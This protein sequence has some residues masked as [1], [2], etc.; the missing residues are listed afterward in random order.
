MWGVAI[1]VF[2]VTFAIIGFGISL[3][4]LR[5]CD[6]HRRRNSSCET[7]EEEAMELVP[8]ITLNPSFNIDMLEYIEASDDGGGASQAVLNQI[9]AVTSAAAA[10]SDE[11]NLVNSP[12]RRGRIGAAAASS[13]GNSSKESSSP[14]RPNG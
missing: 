9:Q 3:L 8:H 11:V 5:N 2:L 10:E 1:A 6:F 7:T 14:A 13:A 12:A 4:L